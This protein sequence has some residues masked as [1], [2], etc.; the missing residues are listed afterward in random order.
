[1]S[2]FTCEN[3]RKSKDDSER[4]LIPFVARFLFSITRMIFIFTLTWSKDIA[5]I[6]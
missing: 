3:C 6:A 1:M 2:E 4:A 5:G